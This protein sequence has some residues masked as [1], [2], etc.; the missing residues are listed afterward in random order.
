MTPT[1]QQLAQA[2]MQGYLDGFEGAPLPDLHE[3]LVEAYAEGRRIG[4]ARSGRL[5]PPRPGLFDSPFCRAVL[6]QPFTAP[7][8]P[9][10][11]V[12]VGAP[13]PSTEAP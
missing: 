4:T 1:P 13:L 10:V 6:A 11:P 7:E 5:P 9:D 8:P 12:P 3:S 2:H